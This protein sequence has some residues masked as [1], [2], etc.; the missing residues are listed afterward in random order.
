MASRGKQCVT[1]LGDKTS[2]ALCGTHHFHKV[3]PQ[4]ST[5]SL[6]RADAHLFTE[7]T[8]EAWIRRAPCCGLP[9]L[10][11]A[12]DTGWIWRVSAHLVQFPQ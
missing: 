12:R 5:H 10:S 7:G 11:T 4:L 3:H 9:S 1:E 2:E 8:A 6:L